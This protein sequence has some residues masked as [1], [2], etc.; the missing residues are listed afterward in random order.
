MKGNLKVCV[1][2]GESDGKGKG[3]GAVDSKPATSHRNCLWFVSFFFL[4]TFK[5]T[6]RQCLV[7]I[8]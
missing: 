7:T 3:K 1:Y 6:E 8:V 4:K 5:A 2:L